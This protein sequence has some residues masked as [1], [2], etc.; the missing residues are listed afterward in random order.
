M[1]F[2]PFRA[3]HFDDPDSGAQG[4]LDLSDV[5]AVPG[6]LGTNPLGYFDVRNL[7]S[8]GEAPSHWHR[9]MNNGVLKVADSA[10]LYIY[11]IG[12]CNSAGMPSQLNG[13]VGV[14]RD[15]PAGAV[16]PDIDSEVNPMTVEAPDTPF[17]LPAAL[18]MHVHICAPCGLGELLV[19]GGLPMARATDRYGNHHRVWPI[20]QAGIIDILTEA[21]DAALPDNAPTGLSL[22]AEYPEATP[23]HNSLEHLPALGMLFAAG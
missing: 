6:E 8:A 21:V 12:Y 5:I 9:W 4:V 10:A 15:H 16:G 20:H 1:K 17:P 19:P 18:R 11:R 23:A 3:I 22:V 2:R 14:T 13:V 7:L